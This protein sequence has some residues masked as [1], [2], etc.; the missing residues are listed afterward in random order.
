MSI[1]E[2][3]KLFARAAHTAIDQRRKYTNEPYHTH[4]YRVAEMVREVG[5]TPT[6]IAAAYLHDVVE[7]TAVTLQVL[8]EEFGCEV[9][10]MVDLLSDLQTPADGNRDTRK[11]NERERLAKAPSDVQTIKLADLIDNTK[12]IVEHDLD[13]A[14]VYLKEKQL[15]LEIMDKG[16]PCL[17]SQ[18]VQLCQESVERIKA[19]KKRRRPNTYRVYINGRRKA[20]VYSE[21]EAWKFIEDQPLGSLHEVR[22]ADDKI[23]PEFIPY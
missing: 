1:T 7:D 18:A 10:Q 20:T 9:T 6:M 11:R 23:R 13:F 17:Y 16:D 12:T 14:G 21:E 19:E 5:G 4:P 3:A 15:L 22:D 2:R 8:Y